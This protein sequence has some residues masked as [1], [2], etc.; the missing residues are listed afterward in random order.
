M[1]IKGL[2]NQN[3]Q[4][5]NNDD[6]I[7][8]FE[9]Q[10]KRINTLEVQIKRLF[11]LEKKL[12]PI[13]SFKEHLESEK[14]KIHSF[15]QKQKLQME[16]NEQT[17]KDFLLKQLHS[18]ELKFQKI[19]EQVNML[20][21]QSFI[22]KK[23]D[24]PQIEN[25]NQQYSNLEEIP[26]NVL[27][28]IENSIFKKISPYF[29][30]INDINEKV[31]TLEKNVSLLNESQAYLLQRISAIDE[32]LD[33]YQNT[34]DSKPDLPTVIKEIHIDKFFLD[35]YEQNNNFA[36]LGIKELSG[37]LNIGATYEKGIIPEQ[38]TEQLKEGIEEMRL[39]HK[40]GKEM[41]SSENNVSEEP[42]DETN[43]TE[44]PIEKDS[45]DSNEDNL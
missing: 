44:I 1:P 38:L 42:F 8:E 23:A 34:N 4:N 12:S 25:V 28:Q 18:Y 20:N 43:F 33:N 37:T 26:E 3:R 11:E 16:K 6:K 30:K 21:E 9:K 7:K 45:D 22:E 40:K 5:E 39:S 32:K 13:L 10:M 29:E 24:I 14:E 27:K 41:D 31:L 15:V 35:K 36:Q 17:E 2:F 19:S